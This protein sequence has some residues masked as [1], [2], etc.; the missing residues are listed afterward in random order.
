S[1]GSRTVVCVVGGATFWLKLISW[2][3]SMALNGD[4]RSG[5]DASSEKYSVDGLF[6]KAP[7]PTLALLSPQTV[8]LSIGPDYLYALNI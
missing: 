3:A 8:S 6:I 1:A 2:L 5:S 4:R 7:R